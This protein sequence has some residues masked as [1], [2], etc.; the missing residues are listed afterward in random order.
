[1]TKNV[2]PFARKALDITLARS[3]RPL[4]PDD[5]VKDGEF[6]S[7]ADGLGAWV[8]QTFISMDAPLHNPRHVHLER[9][10]IGWL[11]TTA[12]GVNRDRSVAGE[13]SR[14]G[15]TRRT[16]TAAAR[17]SQIRGWFG[18]DVDFIITLSAPYCRSID[19]V[20]FCALVEHEL[21]HAAQD[22]DLYG[23][24]RF[25]RDGCP[26]FRIIGHD[27]EEFVDVVARYGAAASPGVQ[28]MVDAANAA[29]LIAP[30]SI[31]QVCG[32]CAFAPPVR[33]AG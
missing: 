31:A 26:V 22:V 8:R 3:P 32:T 17:T 27:V 10:K 23:Q 33:R 25:D 21:C 4:P 24:P 19:D 29:P 30:A 18:E 1:V 9:A 2:V 16:F 7:D 13:C 12:E 6:R 20:T 15:P 28:A 5:L 11:W 14:P